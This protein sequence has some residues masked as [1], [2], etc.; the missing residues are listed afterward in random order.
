VKNILDIGHADVRVFFRSRAAWLWLFL[1]PLAF[2]YFIGLAN[3][4]PGDPANR[5]PS[6]FIDNRDTNFLGRVFLRELGAQGMR[7]ANSTNGDLAARGFLI[8]PDFTSNVLAGKPAKV[9]FLHH[10]GSDESDDMLVEARVGRALIAFNG[11][12]LEAATLSGSLPMLTEGALRGV[13]AAPNPV[14]LNAHFAGRRPVPSGFSLSVP[15]NLIMYLMMNL[16]IFGGVSVSI[17]RRAGIIKRFLVFPT[18]RYE[19]VLGKIYGLMLLGVVQI[20]FLLA[21]GKFLF[22]V[23]LGAN[24]PGVTLTLLVFG[25]VAASF[26]V[27]VGSLLSSEDRVV[28]LCVLVSTLLACLGGCWWP[29]EIGPRALKIAALCLPTGQALD[30]LH[31]LISFG[32]GFDAVLKPIAILLGFGAAANL[33]AIRFFRS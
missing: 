18:T 28:G 19:I 31:H 15:G 21:I 14:T 27:L 8:P 7:L 1:A 13:M 2:T 25:W 24:L 4:G 30:A 12:I 9:R 11:H 3:R 29:L 33:L 26:G 5:R 23:N 6:V 20:A 10:E 16:L 32:S 22:G 17:Q